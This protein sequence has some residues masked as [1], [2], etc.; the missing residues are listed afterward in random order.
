VVTC[1]H[2]SSEDRKGT[3]AGSALIVVLLVASLVSV[4]GGTLV[5]SALTETYIAASVRDGAESLHA[6]D[7]ALARAIVALEAQPDWDAVLAG[8]AVSSFVDGGPGTWRLADGTLLDLRAVTNEWRCGATACT[9]ASMDRS[10]ADRPWGRNNPRW[11]LF[12][13]GPAAGLLPS[14]GADSTAYVA[15]WV[16]DDPAENDGRPFAD[17]GPPERLDASNPVNLGR[18]VL[19]LLAVAYGPGPARR[20]LE[21]TVT[22]TSVPVPGVRTV[23]W[24]EIR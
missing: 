22:R 21:A 24:R 14:G 17:G 20:T 16:G 8:T 1:C 5:L 11:Q 4:L 18:G 3:D 13:S 19:T 23:S 10:T 2:G 7:A 6:A 15:V 12:A 9:D